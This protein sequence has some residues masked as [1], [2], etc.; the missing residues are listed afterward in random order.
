MRLEAGLPRVTCTVPARI[1]EMFGPDG[2][3]PLLARRSVAVS[4]DGSRWV[5]EQNG[6]PFPFEDASLLTL[7]RVRDR[8]TEGAL[9]DYFRGL[10]VPEVDFDWGSSWIV[11]RDNG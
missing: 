9:S 3:P 7:R 8:F 6:R 1:L 10:G 2:T 4:K 11:E 5:F